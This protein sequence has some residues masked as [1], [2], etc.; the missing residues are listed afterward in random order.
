MLWS[1]LT[2][3]PTLVRDSIL[4]A[5]VDVD[6]VVHTQTL[7]LPGLGLEAYIVFPFHR[8][9]AVANT[10]ASAKG[11]CCQSRARVRNVYGHAERWCPPCAPGMWPAT[12]KLWC[13]VSTGETCIEVWRDLLVAFTSYRF[14]TASQPSSSRMPRTEARKLLSNLEHIRHYNLAADA[15]V[16]YRGMQHS[17][18]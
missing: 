14:S 5:A 7:Q 11:L 9:P 1:L 10:Q 6:L 8:G 18:V 17:F 15:E 2:W 16:L 13:P 3:G 12:T 4:D